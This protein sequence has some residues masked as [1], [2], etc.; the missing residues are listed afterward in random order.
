MKSMLIT[1]KSA[2]WRLSS[3]VRGRRSVAMAGRPATSS[4]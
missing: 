4:T 3:W 1:T 2:A